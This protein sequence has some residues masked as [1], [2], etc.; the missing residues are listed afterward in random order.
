VTEASHPTPFALRVLRTMRLHADTYEEI[1]ADPS[2]IGQALC[3]VLA[4]CAASVAGAWLRARTGQPL[5]A[6][7]LPLPWHLLVVALEP[8]VTWLVASAFSYMVGATFFRGPETET[9]YPELLRTTGFAFAPGVLAVF[10]WLEPT[11]LGLGALALA[12]AW[13]LVASIVAVRQALDFT[14]ARAIGTYAVSYLFMVLMLWG[15]TAAPLPI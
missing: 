11:A 15:L 10:A 4:T 1:E 12:R 2:A 3:V 6:E 5:P 8:M 14:T 13:V 9:D 7:M